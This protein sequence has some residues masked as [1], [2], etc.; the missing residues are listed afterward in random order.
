MMKF[1]FTE[2][3]IQQLLQKYK[4]DDTSGLIDY[5][6]FCA[7]IDSVFGEDINSHQII[8]NTKSTAVSRH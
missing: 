5:A 8:N 2:P 3:E 4:L 1:S 7:N 6:S